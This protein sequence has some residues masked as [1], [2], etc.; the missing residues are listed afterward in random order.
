MTW[1]STLPDDWDEI[2]ISAYT[3]SAY[4]HREK[5]KLLTAASYLAYFEALAVA[6]RSGIYD[7]ATLDLIAGSRVINIAE[8]GSPRPVPPPGRR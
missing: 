1:R 7:L 6:V 3:T 4:E 8:N 2:G 5:G